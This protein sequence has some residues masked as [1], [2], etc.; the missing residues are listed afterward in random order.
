M[1]NYRTY[2]STSFVWTLFIGAGIAFIIAVVSC[3]FAIEAYRRTQSLQC[4]QEMDA[5]LARFSRLMESNNVAEV[6]T[7]FAEDAI[8]DVTATGSPGPFVGITDITNFFTFIGTIIR[9]QAVVFGNPLYNG[10]NN[11]NVHV[12]LF[13]PEV[14]DQILNPGDTVLPSIL[15]YGTFELHFSGTGLLKSCVLL[16]DATQVI[17]SQQFSGV[18]IPAAK[19]SVPN[20]SDE[21]N[22]SLMCAWIEK[23][24]QNN[25]TIMV[26]LLK[27]TPEY[28]RLAQLFQKNKK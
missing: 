5:T 25:N 16:G 6:P 2:Y 17:I 4:Q 1:R 26:N 22:W 14:L 21:V 11:E 9:T 20:T 13:S 8:F 10:C 19:R 23:Q 18:Q 28:V 15:T 7:V 24:Q 3:G 12:T 27:N